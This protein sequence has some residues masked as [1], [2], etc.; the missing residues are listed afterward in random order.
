VQASVSAGPVSPSVSAPGGAPVTVPTGP[1]PASPPQ[2]QQPAGVPP[3]APVQST[4]DPAHAV[5]S[6]RP[7][8]GAPVPSGAVP[9]R[10]HSP[11]GA[12]VQPLTASPGRPLTALP[13]QKSARVTVIQPRSR[14]PV[15][16]TMYPRVTAPAQ[17][18]GA[19]TNAPRIRRVVAGRHAFGPAARAIRAVP[20]QPAP[21][22]L[23]HQGPVPAGVETPAI[24]PVHQ[25][26]PSMRAAPQVTRAP[27]FDSPFSLFA[28][29]A[30]GGAA[31]AAAPIP[32]GSSGAA[33]A[34][35]LLL[36]SL[37]LFVWRRVQL[38]TSRRPREFVLS[39]LVPP[40]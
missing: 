32:G 27:G 13:G 6:A 29:W 35:F 38:P 20:R 33:G 18:S 10:T 7:S 23:R 40:G 11:A 28:G 24:R 1:G 15:S 9:S 22:I 17:R 21:V 19:V 37:S 12:P 2:T 34:A 14:H 30:G 25:V 16:S 4:S 31:G 39:H 26:Q 5:T 8:G 36:A 3:T